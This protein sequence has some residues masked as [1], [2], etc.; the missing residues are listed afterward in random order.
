MGGTQV[1]SVRLPGYVIGAEAIFG[2]TGERLTIRHDAG[3]EAAPYIDGILLAAR[4]VPK[5]VG[6]RRGLW[7]ILNQE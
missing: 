5:L 2:K 1:H 6:L 3:N 7:S 4:N